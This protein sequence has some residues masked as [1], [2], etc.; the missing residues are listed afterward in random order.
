M[1]KYVLLGRGQHESLD[2]HIRV[3]TISLAI[4]DIGGALSREDEPCS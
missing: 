1:Y 2:W 4:R 3:L